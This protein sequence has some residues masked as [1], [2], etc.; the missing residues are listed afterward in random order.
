LTAQGPGRSGK[1]R[2]EGCHHTAR[3]E[4]NHMQVW[5]IVDALK[6]AYADQFGRKAMLGVL[7]TRLE[8]E[9]AQQE[10]WL[11]AQEEMRQAVGF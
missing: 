6:K 7:I 5:E 3:K 8:K 4:R 1:A 11:E 10:A 9:M 2:R